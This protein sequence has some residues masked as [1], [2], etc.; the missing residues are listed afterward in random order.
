MARF[1]PDVGADCAGGRC[2]PCGLPAGLDVTGASSGRRR[3]PT[4]AATVVDW[5]ATGASALHHLDPDE[6]LLAVGWASPLT[7]RARPALGVD[8]SPRLCAFAAVIGASFR[9]ASA[10]FG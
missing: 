4:A 1:H 8:G 10:G 6:L 9:A 7:G 3:A 5:D 2:P